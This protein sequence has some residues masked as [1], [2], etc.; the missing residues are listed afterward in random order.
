[1][2]KLFYLSFGFGQS[3]NSFSFPGLWCCRIG[4]KTWVKSSLQWMSCKALEFSENFRPWNS[5]SLLFFRRLKCDRKK[6]GSELVSKRKMC[7]RNRPNFS[8]KFYKEVFKVTRGVQSCKGIVFIQEWFHLF[9][10]K[11]FFLLNH[12][13]I[14]SDSMS[15]IMTGFLP[16][17]TERK[18]VES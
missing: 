16:R 1:M 8:V 11:S 10:V 17:R 2:R 7:G 14:S 15:K 4:G 6:I 18:F 5:F 9:H 13:E 12:V 3:F